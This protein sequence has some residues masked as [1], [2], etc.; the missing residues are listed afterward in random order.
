MN[1]NQKK[2]ISIWLYSGLIL[3]IVMVIIGGITRLTD[4]GLSMVKWSVTGELPTQENIEKA[5]YEWSDSTQGES[6]RLNIQEFKRI[7]FWEYLHRIIGRVLAVLFIIPFV[8]FIIKNWIKKKDI[9]KYIILL[10]LG[11]LQGFLGIYMVWSGLLD[12]PYV[13]HFRLALHLITAFLLTAYIYWLIMEVGEKK[14]YPNLQIN[15]LSKCFLFLL[16]I[17]IIYGAFTAGLKAGYLFPA[18]KGVL[19][20]L[21]GYYAPALSQNLDLIDNPYNIQFFH[22]IFGWVVFFF[23]IYVWQKAR[24]THLGKASFILLILIFFQIILGVA[25]LLFSVPLFFAVS[26]QFVAALLLLA[27]INL[28]FLSTENSQ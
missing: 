1:S 28:I 6:M 27:A 11:A 5:Y 16:V 22:R 12:V 20:S 9:Y 17:Q 10:F 7:Y 2:I 25:T 26:H 18:G 13:S 3:V 14:K 19:E 8:F 23:A 21:F 4:S 24:K 15:T